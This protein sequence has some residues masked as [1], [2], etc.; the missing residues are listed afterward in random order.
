MEKQLTKEEV[1]LISSY[2]TSKGVANNA[3]ITF[4]NLSADELCFLEAYRNSKDDRQPSQQAT[5]EQAGTSTKKRHPIL[6]IIGIILLI[7]IIFAVI[8][9]S[10]NNNRTENKSQ[11]PQLLRRSARKSDVYINSAEYSLGNSFVLT[12]NIDI[13][14]LEV[15]FVF[16]DSNRSEVCRKVKYIGNVTEDNDYTISIGL[17]EFSFSEIL[18]IQYVSTEISGGSV[19]YFA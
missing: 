12:P 8:Q 2:R 14:G 9:C 1:R 11:T 19:S 4:Q 18:T 5:T 16:Y 15:T 3:P 10:L 6:A 13:E 7:V 17:T